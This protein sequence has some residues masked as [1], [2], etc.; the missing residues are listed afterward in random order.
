MLDRV[1]TCLLVLALLGG[2]G[3]PVAAEGPPMKVLV[4]LVAFPEL[5]PGID[6]DFARAQF[7]KLA[8]YVREMS[9]GKVDLSFDFTDWCQLPEPVGRYAISPANHKVDKSR[10][11]KLIQQSID[12]IDGAYDLS[13]YRLLVLFLGARFQDY[14]MVGLCGY[15]GILG[16]SQDI[17]FSTKGGQVVPGGVAIFTWQA[18]PGT[19][20]HDVAHVLGGVRDGKRMVPCLYDQD[21]QAKYPAVDDFAKAL[22]NMGYWDPLSCHFHKRTEPPM[23]I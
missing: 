19:L 11:V 17:Q 5:V 23:G 20:F 3:L 21:L 1:R 9:Y 22:I 15:P 6:Q 7:G 14:G 18:H 13:R 16:W 12:A 4:V 2:W 10:V 8:S